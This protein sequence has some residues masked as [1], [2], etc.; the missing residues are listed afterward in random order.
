MNC[1][2]SCPNGS[3]QL[4]LRPPAMEIWDLV[5][6]RRSMIV[7]V[8]ALLMIIFPLA[9]FNTLHESL[10]HSQWFLWFT[11]Y[12]WLSFL[13]ALALI[14][15]LIK[16]KFNEEKFLPRVRSIYA[17]VPLVVGVYAAY[18]V[19]FLPFISALSLDFDL[20]RQGAGYTRLIGIP[21]FDVL[22]AALLI[23]GL[24][25]SFYCAWRITKS[26]VASK[27]VLATNWTI[28]LAYFSIV[29][30]TFLKFH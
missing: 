29:S 7:F 19:K 17:F 5:R 8:A 30:F 6:V 3:V 11:V 18:Q 23:F 10:T 4:N 24:S 13:A 26:G 20:V 27:Y 22:V 2:R 25:V 9:I 15:L 28:M 21:V 16:N 1:V 14:W 12:Y